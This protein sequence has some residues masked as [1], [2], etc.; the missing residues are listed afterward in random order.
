VDRVV[1]S[2]AK[3]RTGTRDAEQPQGRGQT[4]EHGEDAPHRCGGRTEPHP[5]PP[6]GEQADGQRQDERLHVRERD[7][8]QD[9]AQ[10]EAEVVT[11]LGREHAEGRAVELVDHVQPEQDR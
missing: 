1:H 3:T 10:F 5:R 4:G 8:C 2:P 7:H 6:V 11:D 9:P